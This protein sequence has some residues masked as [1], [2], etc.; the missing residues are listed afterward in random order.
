MFHN[1]CILCVSKGSR[2]TL[3]DH[4]K[5]THC[6]WAMCGLLWLSDDLRITPLW[7]LWALTAFIYGKMPVISV[8]STALPR[9]RFVRY[10]TIFA[11]HSLWDWP[12]IMFSCRPPS[13]IHSLVSVP[14]CWAVPTYDLWQNYVC[15][16]LVDLVYLCRF[17]AA[18]SSN[19][20][21][22]D[23]GRHFSVGVA[24]SWSLT[25]GNYGRL[26]NPVRIVVRV[27]VGYCSG[28]CSF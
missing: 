5:R 4:S 2:H 13:C 6:H 21:C 24:V 11:T 25:C 1:S 10:Q 16:Q 14:I 23:Y 8:L 17:Y 15:F 27:L 9:K 20:F 12:S 22:N 7:S 28:G 19:L 3:G 18:P 26:C